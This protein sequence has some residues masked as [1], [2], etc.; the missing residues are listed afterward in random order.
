MNLVIDPFGMNSLLG[1]RANS[2]KT[3]LN[4][5]SA[6]AKAYAVR[7]IKPAGVVLGNSRTE[8]GI[9]PGHPGW[10]PRAR[11]TYNLA[12][13]GS[14][15]YTVWQYLQHAQAVHPL[16]QAV[17]GLDLSMFNIHHPSPSDLDAAVLETGAQS[18][19]GAALLAHQLET[20]MSWDTFLASLR[21]VDS[22]TGTASYYYLPDGR[23]DSAVLLKGL[24]GTHGHHGGFLVQDMNY[25]TEKHFPFPRYAYEFRD[26]EGRS[27]FDSFRS[28]VR[29]ARQ[30]GIDLRFFISPSH[31]RQWEVIRA[32]G[33]WPAFEAWK[34]ELVV[35]LEADAAAHPEARPFV[36][37]DF[38]G[39]NSVTI[40]SVPA[41]ADAQTAMRWY[42]ES[43]HY[44][45]GVG[46]LVQDRLFDY[47]DAERM[48]PV[49]FG[50]PVRSANLAAHLAA[51]REA[52]QQYQQSHPEDVREVERLAAQAAS[53][54]LRW[55]RTDGMAGRLQRP[56]SSTALETVPKG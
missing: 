36:L 24:Q 50:V 53:R 2:V 17:I 45:K 21:T 13:P 30:E 18:G 49:D 31:A 10:D 54:T 15:I 1:S 12:F 7:R 42:W 33:L 23:V 14:T 55:Q 39:Y 28:I 19:R 34:R 27:T 47:H 6:I 29:F 25:L 32:A 26:H 20:A 37:W 46:D 9:D 56:P 5:H 40:E 38:S 51:I 35:I 3:E 43:S 16:K 48:V 22:Q 52:Q 4:S 11:P 44:K 8:A 41:A